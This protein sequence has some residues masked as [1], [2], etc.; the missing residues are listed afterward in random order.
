MEHFRIK[1]TAESDFD[2]IIEACGGVR[3]PTGTDTS[4]DYLLNEAVLELK[5]VDEEGFDKVSRQQKIAKIFRK[6]QPDTPT[7]II[8][9]RMLD[10]ED[11]RAY[12]NAVEQPIKGHVKKASN[13]LDETRKRIN[14]NLVRV[15]ILINNG[16]T[17]LSLDEFKKI[18]VK[19][20]QNDTQRID[21]VLCGGQYYYSDTFDSY[22]ISPFEAI[23]INLQCP[24]PSAKIIQDKWQSRMRN[25][26]TDVIRSTTRPVTG[27]MP[28]L[29][30]VFELDGIHYVKPSPEMPK[31]KFWPD[32]KRPR[33]NSS[34]MTTCPPV[35][36][37]FPSPTEDEWAQLKRTLNDSHKLET[38]Y[39][40]WRRYQQN[41]ESVSNELLRPF[42]PMAVTHEEF[43]KWIKQTGNVSSFRSLCEHAANVFHKKVQAISLQAAEMTSDSV[44]PATYIYLVINEI[45]QDKAY[46]VSSVYYVSNIPGLERKETIISNQKMFFE[47]AVTLASAYAIKLNCEVVLYSKNIY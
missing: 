42:V 2:S 24:F 16:Y 43:S 9:P 6:N 29:D 28:V 14:P 10:P 25:N 35:A 12:Y 34:G 22:F 15:L 3:I 47:Y 41:A 38:N 17:A 40:S 19:C 33:D 11:K 5:L 39:L 13:Q 27:K 31:S 30:L 45:G 18:C 32:G 20:V 21:W 46:D 26:L 1:T 7:V 36:I 4:S 37:A 23:P 44:V 8:D